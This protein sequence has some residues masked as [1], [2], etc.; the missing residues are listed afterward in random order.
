M[1]NMKVIEGVDI[2]TISISKESYKLETFFK[3]LNKEEKEKA[4]KYHF[5]RDRISYICCRG[6]LR[7][8]L[9]RYINTPPENI[10]F[11]YNNYGK[12]YLI[13]NQNTEEYKF[14]ISHSG[15]LCIIAI[16]I[17]KEIGVDIEKV[18]KIDDLENIA[19]RYYT[20]NEYKKIIDSYENRISNFFLIW[21]QKEALIKASGKGLS[22]GL[23]HWETQNTDNVYTVNFLNE[24]FIIK[25]FHVDKNYCAALSI[26]K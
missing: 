25:T 3:V 18:R 22:Y 13:N 17:Q 6:T 21:V 11:E 24:T 4:A 12:P 14:N 5:S 8:I 1:F 26:L 9:S 20:K 7:L 19:K 10:I 2:Y 23:E 15:D 16:N